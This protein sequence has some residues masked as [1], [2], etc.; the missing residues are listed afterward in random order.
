MITKNGCNQIITV[1]G[2]E[3]E[4]KDSLAVRLMPGLRKLFPSITFEVADPTENIEPPSD[5][6]IIL[7]VGMGIE[8]VV[9]IEDL[10]Q[11]DQVKGQSVHDYDVY[12]DLRLREKIGLLPNVK[13]ILVPFEW[14]KERAIIEIARHLD[15]MV[16]VDRLS[17]TK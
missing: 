15:Q 6:W 2:N 7:D 8:N 11:L 17:P 10:N 9:V 4:E 1:F 13:I 5:P 3:T 14:E 16:K 12:M